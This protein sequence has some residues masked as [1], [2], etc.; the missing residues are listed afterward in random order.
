MTVESAKETPR[1]VFVTERFNL[2]QGITNQLK[3]RVV[4]WGFG[5]FSQVVYYRTYS[6]TKPDGS[7]EQWVDTVVRV[8]NGV[9]S[10]RKDWY[11]KMG[12]NWDEDKWQA[13][14]EELAYAVFDMK[15]LPPGRGLWA[16]GTEYI[17][18][19]GSMALNN[20]GAVDVK[21]DVA[22]AACW[23]MN[24][25]MCGVGVGFSTENASFPKANLPTKEEVVFVVPDSRE[26]WVEATRELINSYFS[27]EGIPTVVFDYSQIR[28]AGMPLKGF[29]GISSGCQVLEK[30]HG[31]IT[32]YLNDYVLEKCDRT[33]LIADIMNSIGACI[34]SGNIRRSAEIAIG[35]ISDSTFMNLKNYDLNPERAE[36]GWMSNNSVILR[37]SSEFELLPTIA[38]R[39]KNNGEP[40]IVNLINIQKYGRVGKKKLDLAI[41][42]NPCSE[43][44]LE[45]H[46]LCN[47]VEVFPS[48]CEDVEE[49]WHIMEIATIYA[50][51]VS[52]LPTQDEKTNAVIA[53]NRRIG[54]S[55]SGVADWIDKKSL[56]HVTMALREGYENHV[57]PVNVKMARE[58][59][60]PPSVRIT[61]V[62]P[63]GT[64]SLLAGVSP[65]MHYPVSR[66]AIRRMRISDNSPLVPILI[67]ADIPN[68]KDTYSDNTLV[69]EFPLESGGGK[70]RAVSEVSVWEQASLVAML[71]RE[72]A[73]NC[74]SNTLTF[75]KSE[76][77]QV[78]RVLAAF[79]PVVKSLSMLPDQSE[80]E[81]AY[82]QP[83]YESITKEHY[84]RLQANIKPIDWSRLHG[85][86]GIDPQFC[87][88][89]SCELPIKEG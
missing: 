47:L 42:V 5:V 73:D 16:M 50:S 88:N 86:D 62:K 21:T 68:E 70:T 57:E 38:Q 84:L 58:A 40:G 71:Q 74:V 89:E 6:R 48:R 4:P 65:G 85:L 75:R 72:W 18:E 17:Y 26:G 52:L 22:D 66:Y 79:A 28:P 39:I 33:R 49:L 31:R 1:S 15:M 59:G 61:T 76:E 13:Y 23:A 29:G 77:N 7:Q 20:C 51:T 56:S 45:D 25:L 41:L 32:H 81:E 43:I 10:I 83:P 63:S 37:D 34:V 60:V 11:K 46:E 44:P 24:A 78:E 55:V 54:V 67:E 3:E 80:A 53:R 64:I 9:M 12:L 19:R 36:I 2:Y 27:G 82:A 14:A 87:G 69:F 35:S 30:L 8:V